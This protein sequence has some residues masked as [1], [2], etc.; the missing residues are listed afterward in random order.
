MVQD[1]T[2]SHGMA[3]AQPRGKKTNFVSTGCRWCEQNIEVH[4]ESIA[5]YL[6]SDAVS[7]GGELCWHFDHSDSPTGLQGTVLRWL[8]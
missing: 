2:A 3:I 8:T 1:E 4:E 7:K 5:K 6:Q